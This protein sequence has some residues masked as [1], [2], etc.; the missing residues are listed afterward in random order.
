[1]QLEWLRPKSGPDAVNTIDTASRNKCHLD[2]RPLTMHVSAPSYHVDQLTSQIVV[3]SDAL[4]KYIGLYT[5]THIHINSI[6]I[7]VVLDCSR[8]RLN[9][10]V[11]DLIKY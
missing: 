2:Y 7:Y 5:R 10:C 11:L 1:V 3:I 9:M 6:Y 8:Y 4:L